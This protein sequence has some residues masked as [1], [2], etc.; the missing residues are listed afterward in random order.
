MRNTR[1][2]CSRCFAD[3]VHALTHDTEFP[4]TNLLSDNIVLL[5]TGEANGLLQ[6]I[7]PGLVLLLIQEEELS[8]FAWEDN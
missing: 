3:S 2:E 8:S 5:Q 4:I 1:T 6:H 7:H